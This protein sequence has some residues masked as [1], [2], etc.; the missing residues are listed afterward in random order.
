VVGIDPPPGAE[1][2]QAELAAA[3]ADARDATAEVVDAV[4]SGGS[5]TAAMLVHEWRGALF[6]VRLARHRLVPRQPL[7]TRALPPASEVR[8]P[9][10]ALA[11]TVVVVFG[12]A[13]FTSGAV[14]ALW[15]LWAAGL[16]LV[17]A[18]FFAYRP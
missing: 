9:L 17:A 3:L 4:D 1:L 11:A 15:Q 14:F 18:G 5:E 10:T 16:A 13:A 7:P 12:V 6:R 2:A 8:R